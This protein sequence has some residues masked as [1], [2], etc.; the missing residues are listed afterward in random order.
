MSLTSIKNGPVHLKD[1]LPDGMLSIKGMSYLKVLN[2]MAY[3]IVLSGNC[4]SSS[5][6]PSREV[7]P[8]LP[9]R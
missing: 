7:G 4:L 1:V 3:L 8:T 9:T 6:V 2:G 5:C